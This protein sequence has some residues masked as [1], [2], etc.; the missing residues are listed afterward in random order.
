MQNT[1]NSYNTAGLQCPDLN[2][3][4]MMI[5]FIEPSRIGV[6]FGS[7]IMGC[8]CLKGFFEIIDKFIT[9]TIVINPDETVKLEL[10]NVANFGYRRDT[11][12]F[13]IS[14]YLSNGLTV[15]GF[16]SIPAGNESFSFQTSA[17]YNTWLQN[18]RN[19]LNANTFLKANFEIP[20]PTTEELSN[21]SFRIRPI[22]SG[23]PL[24]VNLSVGSPSIPG[25][26]VFNHIRYPNGRCRFMFLVCDYD[27][28]TEPIPDSN[29]KHL[30]YAFDD[31]YTENQ[32]SP[33]NIIWR[34]MSKIYGNSS[35]KDLE[36]TDSN[37]CE[38]VWI[39]NELNQIVTI[40][41]LLA[42]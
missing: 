25:T 35:D 42:S 30:L 9:T 23:I 21:K 41:V 39:K 4:R 14:S 11:W 29:K 24:T 6:T 7:R 12:S 28:F 5:R 36:E 40:Q 8:L 19:A 34:P 16:L 15:T 13:D 1:I 17:V 10:G 38:T 27:E 2:D 20:N 18:F 32:L 22:K 3:N 37:L 26:Q 31:N 33:E